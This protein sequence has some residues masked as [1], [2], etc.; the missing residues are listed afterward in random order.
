[1]DMTQNIAQ[2]SS[3]AG[4]KGRVV[5]LDFAW[6][7]RSAAQRQAVVPVFLPFRGCPVRCVFCAQDVHCLLYTSDAA[8]D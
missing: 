2:R 5:P 4:G 3:Q 6:L 8:D 1:M 7:R